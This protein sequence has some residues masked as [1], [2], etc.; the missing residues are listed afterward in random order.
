MGQ[1]AGS[2]ILK[3]LQDA[4]RDKDTIYAVI[5][6]FGEASDG[7]GKYIAAPNEE[8]QARSIEKAVK[9]A[10]Y[11]VDTVEMIEAHGTATIVGDVV[12]V[13]ALKRAFSSLGATKKN[14]CGLTSVKSNIGHLKSAAGI[15]GLIKGVL[16]LHH[17]TL[18]PTAN[19][20][21]INPK[22]QIEDS[23]FYIIDEAKPWQAKKEH[24]RR[25]NVSAFGFGGA[26]YHVAL[27]EYRVEDYRNVVGV[28][29]EAPKTE[30]VAT[31]SAQPSA[32]TESDQVIFFA[33]TSLN[34]IDEQ[35]KNFQSRIQSR[36]DISFSDFCF[37]H[38]YS[39]QPDQKMRLA[40]LTASAEDLQSKINFFIKNKD[41][42]DSKILSTKGIFFKEGAAITPSEIAVMFPGQ[43]SQYL[44][45]FKG[46]FDQHD[47]VRAWF[48]RAD[49]FWFSK[50]A[51]TVSS[52]IFPVNKNEDEALEIL[53]QTQN[54]HPSIF[55]PS[56]ALYDLLKSMGFSAHYMTGH[57]LGEITALAAAEKLSFDD[58]LQLVEQRGYAFHNAKLEDTGK[59]ISIMGTLDQAKKLIAESKI[60]VSVANINSPQ[61]II[62]AGSSPNIDQFKTFLDK[63]KL[64]NKILFVSHAFHSS[65]IQPVA[66]IFYQQ[67]K[68]LRFQKSDAK[69]IMNHTGDYYP[70][71]AKGLDKIPEL[72]RDQILQPVNFVHSIEKLHQDGVRLFVEVGPGSILSSQVKDIL[73]DKEISI[74][75][76]NFKNTDEL[77]SLL[78]LY[79]G[80]FVEGVPIK[81]QPTR[82]PAQ[83]IVLQ[84]VQEIKKEDVIQ[85]KPEPVRSAV[86]VSVTRE[87]VVFSGVSIGLPGSYKEVFRDDNFQQVFE[88]R[89]FIERTTDEER[90][91][92]VD[93][94]ITKLVK[95]DRGP[96]F[97]LLSSL[98]DVIQ[99][100]GKIGKLDMIRDYQ[101]DEKDW[102]NMTTCI[103]M[104]VAAGYEALKDA[105]IPL[106]R[107]YAM[108]A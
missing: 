70:N 29:Y 80:L 5:T 49:A 38:N 45:M 101:I 99:L 11:S 85:Q 93:L 84:Q 61:Q 58:A 106:V 57:S 41:K 95:D 104:G 108:T 3:R 7:K 55:I 76:S 40:V 78:K 16:A 82:Q 53:R 89:N 43:A 79:G 97:K 77:Q 34:D 20:K 10:G 33:G 35:V 23:P 4:V 94:Q 67:V 100:A 48:G 90:Q 91:K 21:E 72:L 83:L 56:F 28:G 6:G 81:P 102:Q 96:S 69:V 66:D 65:V 8:W 15:P 27:E 1:G 14:Y 42:L 73:K 86:S 92:F 52:L 59:M 22:L 37:I 64:S 47:S 24:P 13:N 44:N 98:E 107:E 12:E 25:A 68:D 18:P 63:K 71:T 17:K 103:A 50:H 60:E 62:V 88:G 51:H 105:H 46:I 19:F 2:I 30:T 9:M 87:T 54:A 75:T 31:V 32:K 26:D 36:Q 39:I 74:L